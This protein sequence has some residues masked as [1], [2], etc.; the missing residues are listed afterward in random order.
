MKDIGLN[1]KLPIDNSKLN[2]IM[3]NF[4]NYCCKNCGIFDSHDYCDC[5]FFYFNLRY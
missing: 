3:T 5:S 4:E 2:D 1:D